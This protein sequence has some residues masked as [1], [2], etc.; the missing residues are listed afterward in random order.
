M[1]RPMRSLIGIIELLRVGSVDANF[2]LSVGGRDTISFG[3]FGYQAAIRPEQCMVFVE[4]AR[5]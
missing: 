5:M 4:R 3:G 2:A 1:F